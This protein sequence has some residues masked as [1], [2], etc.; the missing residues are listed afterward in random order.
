[1]QLGIDDA[2]LANLCSSKMFSLVNALE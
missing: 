2:S 1:V